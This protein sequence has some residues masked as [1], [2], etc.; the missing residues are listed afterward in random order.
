M[1]GKR[2]FAVAALLCFLT[3]A[4]FAAEPVTVA[5]VGSASAALWPAEIGLAENFFAQH[6]LAV[7]WVFAP[8]SAAAI[9]QLA[10]GSLNLTIGSGLVNPLRAIN[11]G[12]DLAVVRIEIPY[13][14]YA[15]L[16][17][18]KIK[19]IADLKGKTISVGGA[20]DITRIYLER[21]LAPN[22]LKPGDYDLV[23][24]GATSA[25]YAALQS[26]AADAALLAPPFSFKAQSAGFVNLGEALT[27]ARDLPFSGTV[28]QRGWALAHLPT[29][30]AFLAAYTDAINWFYDKRN[31]DEAV[32]IMVDRFHADPGDMRAAYDYFQKNQMFDRS[33]RIAA[34][35][36]GP[37]V[38]AL[39]QTGD[40]PAGFDVDRVLMK[41]LQP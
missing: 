23:Y 37:V 39:Q 31:R 12:A 41:Q 1:T 5:S 33:G 14:E 28:T 40:L 11:Q 10:A 24:A 3:Q 29:V 6:G 17:S 32:R 30:R 18:P 26:G 8:S 7:D 4:A 16:A 22:G 15:L 13:P 20:K 19:R 38:Q 34:A 25:R 21:M 9:Q 27:Y 35:Q 36:L 2:P